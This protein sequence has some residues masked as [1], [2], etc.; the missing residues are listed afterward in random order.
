MIT[1]TKEAA[2][3]YGSPAEVRTLT[4]DV[5]NCSCAGKLGDGD[6]PRE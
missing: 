4:I 1:V 6:G 5:L 3:G 2:T